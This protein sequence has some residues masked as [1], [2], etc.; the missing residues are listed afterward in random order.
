MRIL[1]SGSTGLIG[2]A[3]VPF[4]AAGGHSVTRLARS[5]T[6]AAGEGTVLWDPQAGS[7][8]PGG[9][10]GFDAVVHLAGENI[11]GGRWTAAQKARIRD[12]R[13]KGTRLLSTSLAGL[14][15]PPRVLICASAMGYYG[16]RG[17][18]V[19]REESPSGSG[20]LPEV[21]REWEQAADLARQKGIRV[22]NLRF[23]L[24]LSGAGGAL[25][26]MLVPFKLG[27]G[28]IIGSGRQYWSWIALDDV[29]GVIDHA[30]STESLQGPVNAVTPRAVTNR[31]F[32][33]VLG[34]VLSRPTLFP[35]PAFAARLALGQMA[36]E[37]LLASQRLEPACLV[38]SAY[39]FR[40]PELEAALRHV[41]GK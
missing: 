30:I 28:G 16:D 40:Y 2:S 19:L 4:L 33:K 11:A 1:V 12:S 36:D 18:E 27:V 35:L 23:G 41:L 10:E 8:G 24:V 37:L 32:T 20:F 5:K 17:E 9:L 22:V 25:A 29:V 15:R 26:R 6:G 14:D 13:V 21:C 7:I 38:A 3:L 39:A 34:K 31:E